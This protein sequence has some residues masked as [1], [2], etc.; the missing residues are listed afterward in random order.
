MVD[1]DL[2]VDCGLDQDSSSET[3]LSDATE[4]YHCSQLGMCATNQMDQK[5]VLKKQYVLGHTNWYRSAHKST[6]IQWTATKPITNMY[7]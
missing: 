1:R 7:Q 4:S 3:S 5:L 2:S 6:H